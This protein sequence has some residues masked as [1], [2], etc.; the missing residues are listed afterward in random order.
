MN[1]FLHHWMRKIY[2]SGNLYGSLNFSCLF[3]A[4]K[5][6]W[7]LRWISSSFVFC[8]FLLFF[9]SILLRVC[10]ARCLFSILQ[11]VTYRHIWIKRMKIHHTVNLCWRM[12]LADCMLCVCPLLAACTFFI[13][14]YIGFFGIFLREWFGVVWCVCVKHQRLLICIW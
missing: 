1:R 11:N 13:Y 8:L 7:I 5:L 12:D 10:V 4:L 3:V 9:F 2:K 14:F 6:R